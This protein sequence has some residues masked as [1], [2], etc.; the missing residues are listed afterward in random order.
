M[1]R[2]SF[3]VVTNFFHAHIVQKTLKLRYLSGKKLR[4]IL[5]DPKMGRNSLN[6]SCTNVQITASRIEKETTYFP[7]NNAIQRHLSGLD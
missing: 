5:L 6:L 2:D 1:G 7:F 3:L 4:I